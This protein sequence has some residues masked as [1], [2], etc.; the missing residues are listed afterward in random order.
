MTDKE[1]QTELKELKADLSNLRSDMASLMEALKKSGISKAEKL[2]D[3]VQDEIHHRREELRRLVKEA[4][5]SGKSVMSDAVEEIGGKVEQHPMSSI[6][7]A[8]GVGFMIAKLMDL[9]NRR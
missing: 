1:V 2:K 8:F 5:A 3:S 6:L 9:G 4:Q 7:A